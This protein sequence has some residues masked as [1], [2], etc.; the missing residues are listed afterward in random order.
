MKKILYTLIASIFTLSVYADTII[1]QDGDINNGDVWTADNEYILDGFVF[2]E[3]GNTLTINAGT[4]VRGKANVTT[5]DNASALIVM[6]GAMIMAEGTASDPI[7]FTA[8]FDDL[9]DPDDLV[10]D[11][12]AGSWGGVI[13]LERE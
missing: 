3:T 9:S 5:G 13:I 10:A 2:V 1:I 8:E 6:R 4:V 7:I 11:L 12:D